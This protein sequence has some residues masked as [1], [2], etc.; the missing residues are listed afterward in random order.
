[1]MK[2]YIGIDIGGTKCAVVLGD[3]EGNILKKVRFDTTDVQSTLDRILEESENMQRD[4]SDEVKAVGISCGGPL[5]PK[6]GVIQSPPNLRGWD[7]IEIARMI[8][9]RTGLP[10]VL[11]NDANACALAEYKFGA[12]RVHRNDH[13]TENM[14]FL[15]FGTG[16][17]AGILI[18]GKL[19]NGANGNAGEIG[20]V[21]LHRF[22]P[23]G[24]GKRGSVEGFVSGG[25]I[26][27]LAKTAAVELLQQGKSCAYCN[28]YAD[29]ETITAKSVAEAV[30]K[31]DKTAREVYQL[32]GE[33]LGY[34]LSILID[35][36]NP[37]MIVIGSIYQRSGHLL[38]EPMQTVLAQ[39]C[40][41]YSLEAVKIVPAELGDNLGDVAASSLAMEAEEK[42]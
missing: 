21:R 28:S 29:L 34:T 39:E 8:R 42:I 27:M 10:A 30:E 4:A 37:D 18:Q 15:T 16:L 20:H 11:C 19:Y 5:D 14:I 3:A 13:A 23:V 31:G 35:I 32:C 41:P 36:L 25:G 26:A 12:G 2:K 24:Y 9:E 22:G 1:M 6:K 7:N 38:I 17:G 40:L 33:M